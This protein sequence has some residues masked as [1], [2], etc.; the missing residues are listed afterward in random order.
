[1]LSLASVKTSGI[2]VI[3]FVFL[4]SSC[5]PRWQDVVEVQ[6]AQLAETFHCIR[7]TVWDGGRPPKT[8]KGILVLCPGKYRGGLVGVFYSVSVVPSFLHL[9]PIL[10]GTWEQL[11]LGDLKA[12]QCLSCKQQQWF[13]GHLRYN[14]PE[15]SL[16][17]S[18]EY[19]WFTC[20]LQIFLALMNC[21]LV[22]WVTQSNKGHADVLCWLLMWRLMFPSERGSWPDLTKDSRVVKIGTVSLAKYELVSNF[23]I[24]WFFWCKSRK[25]GLQTIMM[26]FFSIDFSLALNFSAYR[27]SWFWVPWLVP[28]LKPYILSLFWVK[29]RSGWNVHLGEDIIMFWERGLSFLQTPDEVIPLS[30]QYQSDHVW[31]VKVTIW[32]QKEQQQ[33]VAG[34]FSMLT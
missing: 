15:R 9:A 28:S 5:L 19:K 17:W 26:R 22:V 24:S 16:L 2:P 21:E 14:L 13:R 18:A 27:W 3:P 34:E 11:Y 20:I 31:G 23:K 4:C 29:L 32:Q 30:V 12:R 8:S 10:M 25:A 6:A 33:A 7:D 1:M